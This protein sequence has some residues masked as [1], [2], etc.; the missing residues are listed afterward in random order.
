MQFTTS[1]R[2]N[3][4][5]ASLVWQ[6]ARSACLELEIVSLEAFGS[7]L[8]KTEMEL[9]CRLGDMNFHGVFENQAQDFEVQNLVLNSSSQGWG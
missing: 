3:S 9:S 7:R 2:L 8:L 6:T 1:N 5:P 4:V